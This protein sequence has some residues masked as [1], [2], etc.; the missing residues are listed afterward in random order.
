MV[1][2]RERIILRGIDDDNHYRRI[3]AGE[4]NRGQAVL[5]RDFEARTQQ[6]PGGC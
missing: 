2:E 4:D 5:S 3:Y 1:D 6:A